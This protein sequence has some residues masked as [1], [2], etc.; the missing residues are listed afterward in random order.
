MKKLEYETF[1]DVINES[2]ILWYNSQIIY[3]GYVDDLITSITGNLELKLNY[4][5]NHIS[6]VIARKYQGNIIWVPKMPLGSNYKYNTIVFS[7]KSFVELWTF[8]K[9]KAEDDLQTIKDLSFEEIRIMWIMRARGTE[10][11]D[12]VYSL[13]KSV[14]R[15]VIALSTNLELQKGLFFKLLENKYLANND[16]LVE[17]SGNWEEFIAYLDKGTYDEWTV[18]KK[19]NNNQL[20]M[21]LGNGHSIPI[22]T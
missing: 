17:D 4:G 7:T 6:P 10:E 21:H 16:N 2:I 11:I 9:Y 5:T 13:I 8:I 12:N 3:E 14:K 19:D 22:Y 20:Y 18:F 15:N 1:G